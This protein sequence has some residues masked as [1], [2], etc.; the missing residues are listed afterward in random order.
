MK[1]EET[2]RK[3]EGQ[4]KDSFR[5][6]L[7][8]LAVVKENMEQVE[9]ARELEKRNALLADRLRDYEEVMRR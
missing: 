5:G 3:L 8:T 2:V 4:L 9:K 1:M 6:Q 7:D